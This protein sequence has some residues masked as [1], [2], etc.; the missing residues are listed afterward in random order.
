M[1]RRAPSAHATTIT[2]ASANDSTP[3]VRDT[4][5]DSKNRTI[6]G[7]IKGLFQLAARSVT[8]A[9]DEA[10]RPKKEKR[11]RGG[12][13]GRAFSPRIPL[14]HMRGIV[15]PTRPRRQPRMRGAPARSIP[16]GVAAAFGTA[17][18]MMASVARGL[19]QALGFGRT[20]DEII[21][22]QRVENANR[23]DAAERQR[24]QQRH[25]RETDH[26]LQ[27]AQDDEEQRRRSVF[28]RSL[29][30]FALLRSS[31]SKGAQARTAYHAG[32]VTITGFNPAMPAP[33]TDITGFRLESFDAE[34]PVSLG[35]PLGG[36]D[37]CDLGFDED[38]GTESEYDNSAL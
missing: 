9:D 6:A 17:A 32:K 10:P 19:E 33:S 11:R 26:Y 22:M 2:D 25:R 4:A 36:F 7:A 38:L 13:E 27:N 23:A 34:P 14:R 15:L 24:L 3:A 1:L 37:G 16:V 18:N 28:S 31:T 29:A 21:R 5:G 30:A 12:S 20:A 35:N 8:A